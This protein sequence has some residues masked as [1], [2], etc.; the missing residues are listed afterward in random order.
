M[1]VSRRHIHQHPVTKHH[2]T[3]SLVHEKTGFRQKD[4]ELTRPPDVPNMVAISWLGAA[5]QTGEKIYEA[6]I[7]FTLH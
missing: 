4:A 1:H 5:P 2:L 6:Y 7:F 3:V